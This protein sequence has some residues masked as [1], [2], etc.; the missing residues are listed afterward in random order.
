LTHEVSLSIIRRNFLPCHK[1]LRHRADGFTCPTKESVLRI[2][3]ALENPS[4]SAG[5]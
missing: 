5:V 1:I 4:H 3:I 2:L